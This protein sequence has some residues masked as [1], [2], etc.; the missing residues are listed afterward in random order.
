[1]DVEQVED[2]TMVFISSDKAGMDSKGKTK[3]C[4]DTKWE[5]HVKVVACYFSAAFY[6]SINWPY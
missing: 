2:L 6:L 3:I 4:Y 5:E 1:M